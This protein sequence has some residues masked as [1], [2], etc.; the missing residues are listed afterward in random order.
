M[1]KNLLLNEP[2]ANAKKKTNPPKIG[3]LRNKKGL[4]M[5]CHTPPLKK[6]TEKWEMPLPSLSPIPFSLGIGWD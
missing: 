3:S 4:G 1:L 6:R 2:V 5:A